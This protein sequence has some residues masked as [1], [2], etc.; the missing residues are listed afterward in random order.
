M[1]DDDIVLRQLH[2]VVRTEPEIVVLELRRGVDPSALLTAEGSFLVVVGDDVL[3]Q[4]WPEHL[5]Q[6]AEVADDREVVED[7]V[8]TLREV[9]DRNRCEERA[10]AAED[11]HTHLEYPAVSAGWGRPRGF[12][13]NV[14][15][16][17]RRRP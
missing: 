14:E 8:S 5:E 10:D 17:C 4:F 12:G 3:S 13:L 9:I 11:P 15:S 7:G 1:F 6:I 16:A 2:F